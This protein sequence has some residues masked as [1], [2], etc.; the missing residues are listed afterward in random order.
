MNLKSDNPINV[1]SLLYK[2]PAYLLHV[3]V[4]ILAVLVITAPMVF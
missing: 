4:A 3:G 1:D 2:A